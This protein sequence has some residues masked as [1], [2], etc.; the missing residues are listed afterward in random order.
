MKKATILWIPILLLVIGGCA[1][2]DDLKKSQRDYDSKIS[3]LRADVD[4]LQTRLDSLEKNVADTTRDLRKNQ[5]DLG[6]DFGSVRD[7]VQ[8]M[9]GQVEEMHKEFSGVGK[10]QNLKTRLDDMAF[11]IG[12]L[13][14]F[15]G[16][17]R[18]ESTNGAKV[19]GVGVGAAEATAEPKN[20]VEAA[21]NACYRLFKEGQYVK[22]R[23]EFVK[24]LKQYPKTA[25]SDNAQFWIGETWYVEDKFERAIV[26]Y[27]KVV[28]DYPNGDKVP[29][30]LL[31]QGMAF[32]KLG[33]KASARIVYNQVIKKY[34]QTNQ[35]RVAKAKLSELK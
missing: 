23:E 16:I 19:E 34:P 2:T 8:T 1:T 29:Y 6:A 12:Y 27:Q 28:K 4:K 35:A 25:F 20:D 31:K 15:L 11:R 10:G 9:R 14:N 13:E 33:D 30:A 32:Q 26:E 7:N 17:A 24:F 18:K 21:Y 22:A 5:A 3:A